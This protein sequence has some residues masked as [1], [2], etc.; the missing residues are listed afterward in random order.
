MTTSTSPLETDRLLLR[1]LELNDVAA[2][3]QS[4]PRWEIV[5]FLSNIPWPYPPD[6][7]LAFIRDRA[8][9]AMQQGRAWH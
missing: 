8:L 6:G 1:P 2:V 5:R 9:P 7:A 4:F 3:Q